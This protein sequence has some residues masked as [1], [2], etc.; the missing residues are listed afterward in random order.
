LATLEKKLLWAKPSEAKKAKIGPVDI[1]RTGWCQTSQRTC[2][3][4][5]GRLIY[6]ITVDLDPSCLEI[7]TKREEREN[8]VSGTVEG[9][10][11]VKPI[12]MYRKSLFPVSCPIALYEWDTGKGRGWG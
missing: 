10:T 4:S 2:K 7:E 8:C 1:P 5:K 11:C 3:P 9:H 6:D 12:T